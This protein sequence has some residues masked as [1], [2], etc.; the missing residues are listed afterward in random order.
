MNVLGDSPRRKLY[1]SFSAML[2]LALSIAT[3]SLS[4]PSYAATASSSPGIVIPLYTDPTDSTWNTVVQV[5]NAYPTVPM[6][7]IAD[8]T[9]S[10]AG[11]SIDQNYVSG[12]KNLQAAG[13]I[14]LGYIDTIYAGRAL[15]SV[16]SDA[17]NWWNWYHP[18]GI[19]FDEFGGSAAYYSTL[20]T[21][22]K[23]LGVTYTMGNPGTTVSTSYYGILDSL[24]ISENPSY[25]SLSTLSSATSGYSKSGFGYLAYGVSLNTSYEVSSTQYV[26]WL[27]ITS[28]GG[29]NP[30]NALPSYFSNE[31]AAIDPPGTSSTSST[32]TSTTST[33]SA[34]VTSTSTSSGVASLSITTQPATGFYIQSVVDNTGGVTVASGLY[35]PHTITGTI[36]HSYSV[37]VDDYG[38]SYVAAANVGTF[39]RTSANGGGGTTTFTLQANTNLAFTLSTS[40]TTTTTSTTTTSPTTSSTSTTTTISSTT[41][42]STSS[43]SPI[44]IKVKSV[45]LAG[46][47]FT[48]MY[49]TV[50]ASGGKVLATGYTTLTFHGLSGTTYTVCVYNHLT[51]TFSHWGAGS[52]SSC[53]TVTP[54]TNLVMTAYYG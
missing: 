11:T 54:T 6:I 31:V 15:S 40:L 7:V 10:G 20:N 24:I 3:V 37:T 18:N 44:W 23:A 42:T 28:L 50:T 25:P 41:A 35:T 13:I 12:V 2:L 34:T 26:G 9:S 52:T 14:V 51:T 4:R 16:E 27:Y 49:V 5:H 32:T 38:G 39:T 47:Q 45:N 19:F 1:L 29:G 22:V 53:Q 36:G 17:T 48:G 8:P 21:F 30:W 43:S 33:A 46:V